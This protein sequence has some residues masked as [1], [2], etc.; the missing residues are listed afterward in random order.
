M[1]LFSL[2][3]VGL[4][5][6][7][8]LSTLGFPPLLAQSPDL[9]KPPDAVDVR[10]LGV[11]GDGVTS[12]SMAINSILRQRPTGKFYFPAGNYILE[13]LTV[14]GIYGDGFSGTLTFSPQSVVRC[15]SAD[16]RGRSCVEL[17]N[18]VGLILKGLHIT[19]NGPLPLPRGH[20]AEHGAA[21][22]FVNE[23]GAEVSEIKIDGSTNGGVFVSSSLDCK[24]RDISLSNTS[25]DGF[26]SVNSGSIELT[27]LTTKGTGDDGL[28]VISYMGKGNYSGFKASNVHV[29]DSAA[30]GITVP[31]QSNVVISDFSVDNT[32]AMGV[33]VTT[34]TFFHTNT[35][36][37]VTFTHGNIANAGHYSSPQ[38][39]C[40]AP[41]VS[42][43]GLQFS[44]TGD[45]TIDDVKITGS[46]A[47][48]IAGGQSPTGPASGHVVL[49]NI[50]VSGENGSGVI[51]YSA[52]KLDL[53]DISIEDANGGFWIANN[54]D[55]T[56]KNLTTKN[57]NGHLN[58][59]FNFEKN[60]SVAAGN[61][62]IIDTKPTPTGDTFVDTGNT[63]PSMYYGIKADISNGT[64][65]LKTDPA[66]KVISVSP[67]H[68]KQ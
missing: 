19:F 18:G 57:V 11:R 46:L 23:R 53:S 6:S 63:K 44:N 15:T 60:N 36:D 59:S 33:L 48:A 32:C 31:G 64:I 7:A 29:S 25:A 39:P 8:L 37:N 61:S 17:R 21:L 49:G 1:I 4:L 43:I 52:K 47:A 50:Q 35:P 12:D 20:L 13:N 67:D 27:N 30:R 58:R 34:D 14:P 3:N 40:K 51:I 55:V 2:R 10:T 41:K 66:S 42:G 22:V 38:N 62:H 65:K 45:V 9:A 56:A 54:G 68:P 16:S 5:L 28:S 26:S 24:F